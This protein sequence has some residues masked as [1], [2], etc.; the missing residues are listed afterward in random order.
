MDAIYKEDEMKKLRKSH[1][2]PDITKIYQDFLKVPLG[3]VSH[4][5]LHT[6]YVKR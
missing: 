2:N 1:E 4:K 3:E 5:Y 6:H